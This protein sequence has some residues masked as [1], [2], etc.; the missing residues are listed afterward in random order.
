MYTENLVKPRFLCRAPRFEWQ[1][2]LFYAP[3]C[4]PRLAFVESGAKGDEMEGFLKIREAFVGDVIAHMT[5]PSSV[6]SG[7]LMDAL[8]L[9][10]RASKETAFSS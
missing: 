7:E 9:P 6:N 3:D 10:R 4:Y 5:I 8:M 2:R 1:I